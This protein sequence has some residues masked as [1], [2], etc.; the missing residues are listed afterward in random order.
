MAWWRVLESF[1]T[2]CPQEMT[3]PCSCVSCCVPRAELV[4]LPSYHEGG[5][6]QQSVPQMNSRDHLK[7][8]THLKQLLLFMWEWLAWTR[9]LCAMHLC[10][11]IVFKIKYLTDHFCQL[12]SFGEEI[13]KHF[14]WKVLAMGIVTSSVAQICSLDKSHIYL[15]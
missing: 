3:I 11:G 9:S 15:L 10:F 8:P 4:T 14:L 2:Y 13:T 6:L 1:C 12:F 5:Q 7:D